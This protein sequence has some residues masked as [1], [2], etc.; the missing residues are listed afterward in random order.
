[1]P[2]AAT[3]P[4]ASRSRRLRSASGFSWSTVVSFTMSETRSAFLLR[5]FV[6]MPK[7]LRLSTADPAL[8]QSLLQLGNTFACGLGAKQDEDFKM[9]AR[10]QRFNPR[11]GY[12][13]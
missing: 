13:R 12:W 1:M 4:A 2:P 3:A 10:R 6:Q 7:P 9:L 5:L 8:G 11:I